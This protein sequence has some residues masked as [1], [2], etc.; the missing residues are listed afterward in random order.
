MQRDGISYVF[1]VGPDRRV[2]RVRVETGRRNGGEVEILSSLDRAAEVVTTGGA[3]LADRAL[4]RVEGE[5]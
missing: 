5:A 1:T 3:F 2:A 4:V